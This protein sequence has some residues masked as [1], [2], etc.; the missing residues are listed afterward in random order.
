MLTI[1]NTSVTGSGTMLS[2]DPAGLFSTGGTL[3]VDYGG[4]VTGGPVYAAAYQ[5]NDG[6]VSANL[7]GPGGVTVSGGSDMVLSGANTY[8]GTTNVMSGTLII[9]SST[10]LPTGTALVIGGGGEFV[11]DPT[12]VASPLASSAPTGNAKPEVAVAQSPSEASLQV[13]MPVLSIAP[14]VVQHSG[15]VAPPASLLRQT[16]AHDAALQTSIALRATGNLA[17]L[18]WDV[19]DAQSQQRRSA[20]DLDRNAVDE[21]LADGRL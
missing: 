20:G 6:M 7:G 2:V 12:A 17:W 14:A 3:T 21:L 8:A 13:V 10:A 16:S 15:S 4:S 5:L 11:F 1:T 9:T 19:A 18:W